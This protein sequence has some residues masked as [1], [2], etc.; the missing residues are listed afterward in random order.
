[1]K[2]PD[3]KSL[4]LVALGLLVPMIAAR[5]ARAVT[6]KGYS[7]ITD[8]EPPQNPADPEVEWKDAIIWTIASGIVGSLA[9]LAV[10]RMLAET[11]LPSEGHDL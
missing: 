8:E 9:R 3:T 2:L 4:T 7:L 10:R 6:G 1:M 11:S 5:G